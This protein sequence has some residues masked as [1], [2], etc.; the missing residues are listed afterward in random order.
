M[1]QDT[2][3]PESLRE[4]HHALQPY[5]KQRREA[6][7]VRQVLVAHLSTHVQQN[8]AYPI[9]HPL[10]L[11]EALPSSETSLKG[12]RGVQRE[13]IRCLANNIKAQNQYSKASKEHQPR[14][15]HS[16]PS[17][18][19]AQGTSYAQGDSESTLAT[20]VDT[21][22]CRR[23]HERLCIM[24]EFVDVVAE[25]LPENISQ[26]GSD[27]ELQNLGS[28]PQIPPDV[29]GTADAHRGSIGSDLR[30]LVNQLE[31]AVLRAKLLLQREQRFLEK[32]K[33]HNNSRT[34]LP[35]HDGGILQALGT[36]RNELIQW[37]ETELANTADDSPE[38]EDNIQVNAAESSDMDLIDSELVSI[39]RQYNQYSKCRRALIIAATGHLEQATPTKAGQDLDSVKGTGVPHNSE[40]VNH[41]VYPYLS[42]M[43]SLSSE[44]KALIQQKSHFTISLAKHLKE[45]GQGVDRL[46]EESHLLPAHPM[47]R[48]VSHSSNFDALASFGGSISDQEKPDSSRKAQAWVFAA[49]RARAATR[50]SVSGKIEEGR[51]DI[52]GARRT[53][54]ELQRLLGE[55]GSVSAPTTAKQ[56]KNHDTWATLDGYLGAIK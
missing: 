30:G 50:N 36:T 54:L 14:S 42:E 2:G 23:K 45:A 13:Y 48:T 35:S 56:T 24:Q 5:I 17:G 40:T 15:T 49:D 27:V 55:D 19:S 26:L 28:L 32:V 9:F 51:M 8:D 38:P 37:I 29:M 18:D 21:V 52:L 39:Q 41:T 22:K 31:K 7:R 16:H 12:V 43:M 4:I 3:L 33:H 6:L 20:F 25:K 46:A 44:Q 11:L 1:Q 34:D 53:L 47:P 10:S